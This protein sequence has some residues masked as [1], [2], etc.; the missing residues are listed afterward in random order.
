MLKKSS[1]NVAHVA[2]RNDINKSLIKTNESTSL[3]ACQLTYNTYSIFSM[4]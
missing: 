3:R 2:T 4:F 1:A